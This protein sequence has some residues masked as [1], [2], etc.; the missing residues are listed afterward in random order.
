MLE[1]MTYLW[2]PSC[3]V[4]RVLSIIPRDMA[5]QVPL[6]LYR[7]SRVRQRC[8]IVGDRSKVNSASAIADLS[9]STRRSIRADIGIIDDG[10]RFVRHYCTVAS[11]VN[12]R[13]IVGDIQ[14]RE[15]LETKI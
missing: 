7:S 6:E 12:N 8:T 15:N 13:W 9:S 10:A 11:R 1:I 5:R 3:T 14:G 2:S 4:R